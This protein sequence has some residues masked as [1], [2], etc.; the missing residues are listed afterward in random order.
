MKSAVALMLALLV[1]GCS[2]EPAGLPANASCS[3]NNDCADRVCHAGVCAASKLGE[4]GAPCQGNGECKTFNC[5]GGICARGKLKDGADC[6]YDV[7]CESGFC[8]SGRKCGY[9]QRKD[10]G[11][12]DAA[13]PDLALPDLTRPD[14]A[15]PDAPRPDSAVPDKA[16]PDMATPDTATPDKAIPDQLQPDASLCGNGK[17]DPTELCDGTLLGGKT[18][19]TQG[20]S[21]G[22][23][24]CKNCQLD[25]FRCYEVRDPG[26]IKIGAHGTMHTRWA[27]VAS[28][29]TS[30]LVVWQGASP[31]GGGFGASSWIHGAVID[32]NGKSGGQLTV[33]D[34]A[35]LK[36][37]PELVFMGKDYML[38]Y[39]QDKG[40]S[41]TPV[42]AAGKAK[43]PV[44][45]TLT[46]HPKGTGAPDLSFDGTNLLLTY[47]IS[48][49]Q[50]SSAR[51]AWARRVSTAGAP[52]GSAFQVTSGTFSDKWDNGPVRAAFDG[53]NHLAVWTNGADL[54]GRRV[55][56]A[57]KLVE[58]KPFALSSASGNQTWPFPSG[59]NNAVQVAWEDTQGGGR[60]IN[61]TVVNQTATAGF[62]HK[63]VAVSSKIK[64]A[65]AVAFDGKSWLVVYNPTP[66]TIRA[67]RVDSAGATVDPA[68]ITLSSSNAFGT[69][70]PSVAW[71][72]SQYLVGWEDGRSK[73]RKEIY[74]TRLRFGKAP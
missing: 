21:A 36:Q 15:R 57:G 41:G 60:E 5:V 1:A 69:W 22:K 71:D 16:T 33:I 49:G 61:S 56:P 67:I 13:R 37:Y 66:S 55:S 39:K 72:G 59:G 14:T 29:G 3:S 12:P 43:N 45:A 30:F 7:E 35:P 18:C 38:A 46:T 25:S 31:G 58:T 24:Q 4:V 52:V 65:P 42:T 48:T 27:R 28:D 8:T 19:K 44:G 34:T 40:I 9:P 64:Y 54:F 10:A 17:L 51:Q 68:A 23:L 32:S 53:Q 62:T 26:N 73:S 6:I 11:V 50:Y 47:L 63:W 74:G 20:F 2:D 70:Q